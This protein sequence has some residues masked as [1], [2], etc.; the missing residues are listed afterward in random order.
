MVHCVVYF[1][2]KVLGV[3]F[4]IP[5]GAVPIRSARSE[6][7]AIEAAKLKFARLQGVDNWDVRADS[8]DLICDDKLAHGS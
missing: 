3:P 1:Y 8:F 5:K 4:S 2:R 7:R 6:E